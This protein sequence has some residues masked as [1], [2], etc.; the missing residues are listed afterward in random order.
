MLLPLL[1][2]T[3]PGIFSTSNLYMASIPSLENATHS[4]FKTL[5][6]NN[7]ATG[8]VITKMELFSFNDTIVSS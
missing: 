3:I 4:F 1:T 5:L 8:G 6:V 7:A 2:A